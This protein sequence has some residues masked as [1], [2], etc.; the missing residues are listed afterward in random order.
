MSE[1]RESIPKSTRPAYDTIVGLIDKV[2]Q[3][4]LNAEYDQL[5]RRLAAALARKRP[6]P[7]TRGKAAVW[8]CAIVYAIGSVNFLFDK[9]QTPHL[10]ADELC[11]L[12]DVSPASGS[13]KAAQ[14]RKMFGMFQM[15]PRWTLPSMMDKNPLVWMLSVNGILVDIRYAPRGAQE[16]AYRL[17]LIPY[18]PG[19]PRDEGEE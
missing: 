1:E 3:E 14:I 8:A 7:I 9:S 5:C 4:H 18:I 10:R 17:G 19:E 6:S 11:R 15:D 2:C 13:A 12:F 16:E